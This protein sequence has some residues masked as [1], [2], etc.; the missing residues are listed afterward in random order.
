MFNYDDIGEKIKGWAKWVAIV[1]AVGAIISG[2]LMM[3][4]GGIM[5]INGIITAVIGSL[6]AWVSSWLLYGLGE[7]VDAASLYI[8]NSRK[9]SSSSVGNGSGGFNLVHSTANDSRCA[10]CG[11]TLSPNATFCENCGETVSKNRNNTLK[12]TPYSSARYERCPHC[13]EIVKSNT[14]DMCGKS[15]NL[16]D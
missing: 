10:Y 9:P 12:N 15:N 13:G 16:F 7:I 5:I 1:E 11:K 2:F 6:V 4:S 8:H 14:C 3:F